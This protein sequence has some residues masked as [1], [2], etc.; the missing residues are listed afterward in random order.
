ME[1]DLYCLHIPSWHGRKVKKVKFTLKQA[2]KAQM[3]SRGTAL[4]SLTS[5]LY[6]GRCSTPCPSQFT[7][8]KETQYPLVQEVEWAPGLV[9][10]SAENVAPME[11]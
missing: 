2:T 8:R 11:I 7:P 1:L 9:W 6:L 5:A 4:L 10:T 3:V